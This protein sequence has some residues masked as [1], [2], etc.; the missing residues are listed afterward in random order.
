MRAPL[1]DRLADVVTPCAVVS[2][3][4]LGLLIGPQRA[5][6]QQ[7]PVGDGPGWLPPGRFLSIASLGRAVRILL[8]ASLVV[9]T[10]A[11][12]VTV[13]PLRSS[14]V[15]G[16]IQAGPGGMLS[17]VLGK[18]RSVST[19]PPIDAWSPPNAT[20]LPALTRY[21]H[22]CTAETDAILTMWFAPEV[23]FYADRE[24]AGG[25]LFF[26]PGVWAT[27]DDQVDTLLLI[28]DRP[29]VFVVADLEAYENMANS[30][31]LLDD[32]LFSAYR[33]AAES[34]FGGQSTWFR[35]WVPRGREPLGEYGQ[36]ALPCYRPG[37]VRG[38]IV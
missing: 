34:R 26:L 2:A 9:V 17:A 13:S 37:G 22:E 8:S 20:G 1:E 16:A 21:L 5:P 31:F 36:D 11:S 27:L 4:L 23:Y 6:G 12:V 14:L 18:L 25:R 7:M 28:L 19:T 10:A 3:W 15:P 29:P 38:S 32:Y 24:F 30:F 35:V 33:I